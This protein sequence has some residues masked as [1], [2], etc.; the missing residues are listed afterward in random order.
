[1]VSIL[2]TLLDPIYIANAF[3]PPE[4][5]AR[6]DALIALLR[7]SLRKNRS[8]AFQHLGFFVSF[9]FVQLEL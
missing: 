8:F 1:M 5:G 2:I 7:A 3:M 9:S 6:T 4:C